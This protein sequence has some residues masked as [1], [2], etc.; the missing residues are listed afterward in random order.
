MSETYS[1]FK[2]KIKNNYLKKM[3]R[4]YI[5]LHELVIFLLIFPF[6]SLKFYLLVTKSSDFDCRALVIYVTQMVYEL[7]LLILI[8]TLGL[9]RYLMEAIPMCLGT[10][11]TGPCPLN[12]SSFDEFWVFARCLEY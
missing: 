11:K 3:A 9:R 8:Y 4:C 10:I 12:T 5:Y 6:S 2:N 7:V 1:V